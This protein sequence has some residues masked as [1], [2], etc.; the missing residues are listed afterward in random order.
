MKVASPL[1]V[2]KIKNLMTEDWLSGMFCKVIDMLNKKYRPK[3]MM[4][5]VVQKQELITL[6]LKGSRGPDTFGTNILR[7]K[8]EYKH[9][10]TEENKV[11]ALVGTAGPKYT[12]IIFNEK[13]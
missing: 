12:T 2:I 3:D 13:E 7:L 6:K 9:T 10:L 1:L 11:A 8:I 4:L 5:R